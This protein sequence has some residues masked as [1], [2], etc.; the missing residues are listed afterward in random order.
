MEKNHHLHTGRRR[1]VLW[2]GVVGGCME[3]GLETY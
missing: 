1:G 3:E 2:C